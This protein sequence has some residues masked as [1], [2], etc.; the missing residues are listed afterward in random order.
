MKKLFFYSVVFLLAIISV[1][2]CKSKQSVSQTVFEKAK[3]NETATQTKV[4]LQPEITVNRDTTPAIVIK[5]EVVT[6]VIP[7]DS[8]KL[9]KYN[10]VIGSF[11]KQTN[12]TSLK[13]KMEKEGYK[14]IIAQNEKQMYRV[15][16]ASF[17]TKEDAITER[18]HFKSKFAPGFKDTWLFERLE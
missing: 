4:Q 12:A 6:P 15:I 3:E 10:I 5:K 7:A 16:I 2:S 11:V 1:T 8:S 17:D 9:R 13:T 14:A 18:N